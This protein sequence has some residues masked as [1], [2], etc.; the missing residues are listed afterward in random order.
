MA[1]VEMTIKMD[2]KL[3][4]SFIVQV[5]G[6]LFEQM[7]VQS[8]NFKK[9]A[10]DLLHLEDEIP[11]RNLKEYF[12]KSVFSQ[13]CVIYDAIPSLVGHVSSWQ[14][15]VIWAAL[16]NYDENIHRLELPTIEGREWVDRVSML[17]K[18]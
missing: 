10:V 13:A 8:D 6:N 15:H 5:A 16:W 12:K 1:D 9:E 7:Y 2:I 17:E 11:P 4:V 3:F 14:K 18:K